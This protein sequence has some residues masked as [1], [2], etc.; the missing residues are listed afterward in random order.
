MSD[1]FQATLRLTPKL[2]TSVAV[3][4]FKDV[5]SAVSAVTEVLQSPMGPH[6]RKSFCFLFALSSRILTTLYM[7]RY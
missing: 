1:P 2:P 4:Q 6:V 7:M 5:E 3:A